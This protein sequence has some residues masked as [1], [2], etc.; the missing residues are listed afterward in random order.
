M[1][2]VSI[3]FIIQAGNT[4]MDKKYTEQGFQ[5]SSPTGTTNPQL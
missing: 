4:C 3:S 1:Y 2:T 5:I